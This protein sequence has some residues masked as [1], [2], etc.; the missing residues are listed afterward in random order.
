MHIERLLGVPRNGLHHGH[1]EAD[2]GH[3]HP[4]HDI[5]MKPVGFGTIHHFNVALKV[6][7][8]GC[9]KRR[10]QEMCHAAKV[11]K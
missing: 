4:V 1:A 2:V 9:Q 11:N 6:G 7:K 8:I 10:S 3:K 5:E